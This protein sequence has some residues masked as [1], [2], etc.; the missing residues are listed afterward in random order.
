MKE[1]DYDWLKR[2]HDAQDR[3]DR[4]IP[5]NSPQTRCAKEILIDRYFKFL[6]G[7]AFKLK[8]PQNDGKYT[9]EEGTTYEIHYALFTKVKHTILST[10]GG[11]NEKAHYSYGVEKH[12]GWNDSEFDISFIDEKGQ[13][14]EYKLH[15]NDILRIK[16]EEITL[17]EYWGV[18]ELFLD[19]DPPTP[20][21]PNFNYCKHMDEAQGKYLCVSK[22][23]ESRKCIGV[24]CG[25]YVE[26]RNE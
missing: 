9:T 11:R 17:D 22:D 4:S 25:F 26:T 7:R 23:I 1:L 8:I 18:V 3:W 20:K 24:H 15:W 10:D 16:Y 21:S 19:P 13:K 6:D 5:I 14:R 12:L 2:I